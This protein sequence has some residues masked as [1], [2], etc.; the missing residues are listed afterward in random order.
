MED[1]EKIADAVA[2]RIKP[3]IPVDVDLWS[4]KELGA[5]FKVS[6]RQARD[7]IAAMPG[8]PQ[9][10]RLPSPTGR[11]H[12]RWKAAEVIAWAEGLREGKPGRPRNAA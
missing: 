1:I 11:A 4:A 6:E 3:A 8:F 12:P 2:A 10:L 9:P 7:R 5:Y